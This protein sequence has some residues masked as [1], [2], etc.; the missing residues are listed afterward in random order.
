MV[1]VRMHVLGSCDV[2]RPETPGTLADALRS[3][4]SGVGVVRGEFEGKRLKMKLVRW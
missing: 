2:R 4:I 3:M 1:T